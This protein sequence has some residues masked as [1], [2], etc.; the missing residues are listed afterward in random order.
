MTVKKGKAICLVR[1][2]T[3]RQID[4]EQQLNLENE[5]KRDGYTDIETIEEK[6]SGFKNEE[7]RNGLNR[8]KEKIEAGNV[9]IVYARHIDRISRKKKVLFSILEYLQQ[10]KIQLRIIDP[11]IKML[12]D[13]GTINEGAEMLF[14]FYAQMAESEMRVKKLRFKEGKDNLR[15]QNLF[16]GHT[17]L[18][19]YKVVDKMYVIKE[20]DA[21][22]VRK[23][24]ELYNKGYSQRRVLEEIRALGYQGSANLTQRGIHNPA[25]CGKQSFGGITYPAI[26]SEKEFQDAQAKS[27]SKTNL[28]VSMS[29]DVLCRKLIMCPICKHY[30]GI[31]GSLYRCANGSGKGR[32]I[33]VECNNDCG[34]SV[35]TLDKF[36][37]GICANEYINHLVDKKR[38]GKQLSEKENALL[39]RKINTLN[40][41][42][43]RT[44]E[45]RARLLDTYVKGIISEAQFSKAILNLQSITSAKKNEIASMQARIASNNIDNELFEP[46]KFTQKKL[47]DIQTWNKTN[48]HKASRI[49]RKVISKIEIFKNS[50]T[51]K[52][53]DIYF[54]DGHVEKYKYYPKK[55]FFEDKFK[56]IE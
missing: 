4:E 18:Y 40:R 9:S 14:T 34:I 7:D 15:K 13:D 11:Y 27:A 8:L 24:F 1:V 12:N 52:E 54:V 2:S 37:W 47:N 33:D 6:E 44:D 42:I 30:Y 38:K 17:I 21:F 49:V 20:D 43:D 36:I 19:G 55:V 46:Q 25:Y 5:A 53:I 31:Q 48:I 32:N 50:F 39:T 22:F 35:I 16:T 26:V 29:R 41:D 45:K 23:M 3:E 10:K 56:P 51:D 28:I